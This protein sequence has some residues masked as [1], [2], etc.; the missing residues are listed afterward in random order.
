MKPTW[1]DKIKTQEDFDNVV[2]TGMAY[3]WFKDLPFSWDQCI[4]FK[5]KHNYYDSV[6]NDNYQASLRIKDFEEESGFVK[7]EN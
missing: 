2:A 5:K 4:D 3:V 1:L 6:K 7:S